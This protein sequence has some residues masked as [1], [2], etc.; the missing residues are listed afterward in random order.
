MNRDINV[1]I[2]ADD[3]RGEK[4]RKAVRNAAQ[5]VAMNQSAKTR[6]NSL[7]GTP[8]AV[9]QEIPEER[10]TTLSRDH[11]RVEYQHVSEFAGLLDIFYEARMSVQS[12]NVS[13][14]DYA[15][16]MSESTQQIIV[17]I[18]DLYSTVD[19]TGSLT[20][21]SIRVLGIPVITMPSL[22]DNW[23]TLATARD[24]KRVQQQSSFKKHAVLIEGMTGGR[25]RQVR[26][27]RGGSLSI[28][29]LNA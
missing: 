1:N 10:L 6:Q 16:F 28:E 20:R 23:T 2:S 15:W 24:M 9:M 4:L 11:P 18:L 13:L 27:S 17:K 29:V 5:Q 22:P 3:L 21:G 25:R 7:Y 12:E 19:V 14:D 8:S 26:L